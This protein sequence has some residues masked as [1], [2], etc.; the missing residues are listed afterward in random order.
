MRVLFIIPKDPPPRLAPGG[1]FTPAFRAFVETCL[2]VGQG[3]GRGGV[4]R[5]RAVG[6]AG[7]GRKE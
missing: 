1:D 4:A 5:T 2:Q 3:Q 6:D 7:G